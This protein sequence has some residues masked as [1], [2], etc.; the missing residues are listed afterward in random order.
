MRR[1]R[2]ILHLTSTKNPRTASDGLLS[3]FALIPRT[4]RRF[5]SRGLGPEPANRH[6]HWKRQLWEILV[7]IS[8]GQRGKSIPAN[9]KCPATN[10]ARY[11]LPR[12]FDGGQS[13][14]GIRAVHHSGG[15]RCLTS[16]AMLRFHNPLLRTGQPD[17]TA[18]FTTRR[19]QLQERERYGAKT[20]K[21]D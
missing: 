13:T 4:S 14:S 17:F 2:A 3:L 8:V 9:L 1:Y 6:P 16:S 5:S 20:S 21:R 7:G 12:A 15:G 10:S 19:W 18:S 11:S